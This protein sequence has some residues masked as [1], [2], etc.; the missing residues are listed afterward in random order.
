MSKKLSRRDFAKSGAFLSAAVTAS[1]W[2]R[3]R[4]DEKVA[5]AN[6][7]IQVGMIGVGLRGGQLLNGLLEEVNSD[8]LVTAI[9]DVYEPHLNKT[10]AMLASLGR[11]VEQYTDFRKLLDRRDLDAVIIATPDHWHALQTIAACR[12]GKDVYVEK[13]LSMTIHEGRRMVEVSR[14]SGRIVQVG[15]QR[16]SSNTWQKLAHM[17]LAGE[18]GKTT[19]SRAYRI[20]NMYP[21]GIGKLRSTTPPSDLDWDM[22]LGPRSKRPYQRNITPYTFRWWKDYS[23]QM[24]NWGVHY[25]DAMR[26]CIGE[27]APT[28]I[29]ALGGHFAIEDDRTIPDTAQAMFQ[30]ASGHLSMFGTYEAT[31]NPILRDGEMEI[32]GTKGTAYISSTSISVV[33]E[34]GGQFQDGTPR[35]DPI[36]IHMKQSSPSLD[37]THIRNFLDC[38]KS[39]QLPAADIEIGHRSTTMALLANIS[40][41]TKSRLEWD[42]KKEVVTNVREANNYLH[43]DYRSPWSLD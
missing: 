39:R 4:G 34:R 6:D 38:V 15:T 14:E 20:S 33:P 27:Q 9:C 19:L 13:P 30:F 40:L 1:H 24:A 12:S 7:R 41:A 32:R 37:A 11:H 21:D 25:L 43:Y 26:W 22:W 8:A 31:G 23:S 16:R 3:S 29:C 28:S 5:G 42:A 18:L 35:M 36:D 10:A 2:T 17:T